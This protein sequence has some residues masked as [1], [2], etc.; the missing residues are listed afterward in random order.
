MRLYGL[1]SLTIV[2]VL[3][4][5]AVGD[6]WPQWLGPKR[7]SVGGKQGLWTVF[8][9]RDCAVQWRTPVELG[10]AG[11]AVADG[12]VFV[13]DYQR[14]AGEV[15]NNPGGPDRLE[16]TERVLCL[17]AG[18]GQL[19]LEVPVRS[20]LRHFLWRRTA[21]HADRRRPMGV[22]PRRG[23]QFVLLGNPNR[24]AGLE[25]GF[26]QGLRCRVAVL[27]RGRAPAG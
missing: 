19:R 13:M 9:S 26:C 27:G 10:Y 25:Q 20:A 5:S 3:A 14:R 4:P 21:V 1:A 16:G 17:D 6:D 24:E 15:T 18:T 2:C 11:P 23:G 22:R 12:Q 7:D 8:R